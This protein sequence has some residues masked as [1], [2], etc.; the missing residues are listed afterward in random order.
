MLYIS[1]FF[2]VWCP[3]QLLIGRWYKFLGAWFLIGVFYVLIAC[4]SDKIYSVDVHAVMARA[5]TLEIFDWLTTM[6]LKNQLRVTAILLL[7]CFLCGWLCD[8]CSILCWRRLCWITNIFC[9]SLSSCLQV[10]LAI[11]API[12][13]AKWKWRKASTNRV[14]QQQV[15]VLS[16]NTAIGETEKHFVSTFASW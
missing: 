9:I 2:G 4:R 16:V 7:N 15:A 12:I 13:T 5:K 11:F 3:S 6:A 10:E 1:I 14:V 8:V